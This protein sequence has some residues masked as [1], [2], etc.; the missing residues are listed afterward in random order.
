MKFDLDEKGARVKVVAAA[1]GEPFCVPSAP[2]K[3][4]PPRFFLYDRPFFVLIWRKD[5]DWPYFAAWIDGKAALQ[6]KPSET[7]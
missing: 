7:K 3:P 6:E 4:K 2:P 1:G 5:A